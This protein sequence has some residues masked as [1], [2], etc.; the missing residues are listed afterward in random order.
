[1][2]LTLSVC[3]RS[4]AARGYAA[5]GGGGD[6]GGGGGDGGGGGGGGVSDEPAVAAAS[7][8]GVGAVGWM[9]F[10]SALNELDACWTETLDTMNGARG[11]GGGCGRDGG[12]SSLILQAKT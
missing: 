1:M 2:R 11:R 9:H 5:G 6:G 4:A 12:G 10:V 3:E 8:A 7:I